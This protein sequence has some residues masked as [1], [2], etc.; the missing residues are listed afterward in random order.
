M[1]CIPA[2]RIIGIVQSNQS[3]KSWNW[4]LIFRNKL[5]KTSISSRCGTNHSQLNSNN[6]PLKCESPTSLAL[7]HTRIPLTCLIDATILTCWLLIHFCRGRSSTFDL[8]IVVPRLDLFYQRLLHTP[9][10]ILV[11]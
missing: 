8:E 6:F 9:R 2:H 1:E 3:R 4:H 5:F 10:P 7:I 11:Y